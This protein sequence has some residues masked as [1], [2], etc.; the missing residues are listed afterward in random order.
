MRPRDGHIDAPELPGLGVRFDDALL[1]EFPYRAGRN[2]MILA[3]EKD[4]AL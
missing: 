1:K 3:E 4:L 2:T